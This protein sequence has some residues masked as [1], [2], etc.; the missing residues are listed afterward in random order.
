M[1]CLQKI[2]LVL[3]PKVVIFIF[4]AD[5]PHGFFIWLQISNAKKRQAVYVWLKNRC[6]KVII[7][8]DKTVIGYNSLRYSI[9]KSPLCNRE[10]FLNFCWAVILPPLFVQF[11]GFGL[12]VAY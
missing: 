3:A 5:A 6:F 7:Q 8:A 4:L 9:K 2:N 12:F 1:K 11:V 10:G